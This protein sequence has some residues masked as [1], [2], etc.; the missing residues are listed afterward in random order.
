MAKVKPLNDTQIKNAKSTGKVGGGWLMVMDFILLLHLLAVKFGN[1]VIS[2][3]FKK[4]ERLTQL[5]I[6][7][8]FL[9]QKQDK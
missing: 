8:I 5:E 3:L 2:H 9:F 4:R 1:F 6:I 7:L